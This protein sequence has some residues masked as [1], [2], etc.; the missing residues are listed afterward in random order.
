[1]DLIIVACLFIVILF[2]IIYFHVKQRQNIK[3]EFKTEDTKLFI[4]KTQNYNKICL[5]SPKKRWS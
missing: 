2:L 3:E 4:K 1:M 5:H